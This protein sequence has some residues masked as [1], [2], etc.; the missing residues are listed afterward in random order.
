MDLSYIGGAFKAL[1]LALLARS[2]FSENVKGS[3][4]S[5]MPI[6]EIVSDKLKEYYRAEFIMG[7]NFFGPEAIKSAFGVNI[8]IEDIPPMPFSEIELKLSKQLNRRLILRVDPSKYTEGLAT[9]DPK[10]FER[11]K[12]F[13]E[14]IKSSAFHA[15]WMLLEQRPKNPLQEKL[16]AESLYDSLLF[17]GLN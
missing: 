17:Y 5:G 10:R 1:Q 14:T 3:L 15:G 4:T 2:P 6:P 7:D 9:V 8:P 16:E 12:D 11:L 13:I